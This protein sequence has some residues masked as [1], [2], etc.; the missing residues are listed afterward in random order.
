MVAV[1]STRRWYWL[2]LIALMFQGAADQANAQF[3]PSPQGPTAYAVPQSVP[4]ASQALATQPLS[5]P[6]AQQASFL[7][8]PGVRA[9]HEPAAAGAIPGPPPGP[10]SDLVVDVRVV[11]NKRIPTEKLMRYIKTR[12]GRPYSAEAVG[13]D[14][15]KLNGSGLVVSV[16]PQYQDAPNGQGRIVIYEVFERATIR[17]VHYVGNRKVKSRTLAKETKLKA[18]DP[19]EPFNVEEARNRLETF[20]KDKGFANARV[21]LSEGTKPTDERVVFVINEGPKQTILWASFEGNTIASEARLRTLIKSKQ[22]ILW[23]FGGELNRKQ[24]EE[25]EERLEA[26]YRSLGFFRASVGSLI[27]EHTFSDQRDWI[28]VKFVID[29]GP[30]YCVRNLSVVGN[31]KIDTAEIVR[32]IAMEQGQ[33][34]RQDDM[35]RDQNAIKD[36]YGAVGYIFADVKPDI[37]FLEEPG[38]LDLVY[39]I[40]EGERYRVGKIDVDIAGD[41]PHTQITTVLNRLSLEPGDIIDIRELRDSQRRLRASQLFKSDPQSGVMPEIAFSPPTPEEIEKAKAQFARRQAEAGQV[42]GQNP[43]GGFPAVLRQPPLAGSDRWYNVTFAGQAGSANSP[44]NTAPAVQPPSQPTPSQFSGAP[45][46]PPASVP[47]S[48][49]VNRGQSPTAPGFSRFLAPARRPGDVLRF[50]Y[51]ADSGSSTPPLPPPGTTPNYSATPAAP[52]TPYANPYAPAPENIAPNGGY[53][54]APQ[55]PPPGAAG[56]YGAPNPF[57]PGLNFFGDR[58]P[59]GFLG[60]VPNEDPAIFLPLRPEVA[61]TETGRFMFSAGVNSDAGVVG[62]VVVDEQNFDWR[63]F[64][65]GWEDFRNGTAFRGRGQRFRAEAMPGTEVQRYMVTFQEPYLFDTQ[66]SLG[67]NGFYYTRFFTE[68]D[69]QRIGGRVSLGYQLAH[70]L[71]ASGSFRFERVTISNPIG[72]APAELLDVV[73]DSDLYGFRAQLTHDTRDSTF[74]ATEGHLLTLA[75]EQV[76][77]TYQYPRAEIDLRKYFML[78]E[79]P[80]GSGRHVLSMKGTVNYTGSDTPIYEHYF[81]GGF[82]TIRGFD[83]RGASPRV[84]GVPV[85]G[86]FNLLASTEYMF[87]LTA[88]DTIRGVVFCDTGAAQPTIDNWSDKYRVAPG[89]GLRLTIP[90]MGPAPIA[91]DFAFPVVQEDGDEEEVFSF[92]IGFL[93]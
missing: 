53:V 37:R 18:G 90:A 31:K 13:E 30:R 54:P 8:N 91:L 57:D 48:E 32:V 88:S 76:I 46:W 42:R 11:G 20:Y 10:T 70:D 68:W 92:F 93:R 47:P 2:P 82:S 69:E 1:R 73:G 39:Q 14:V 35:R 55:L 26:Y 77:G 6:T 61:E 25:D 23:F 64:P 62:S 65:R 87:P 21:T 36:R 15:R 16:R 83:F 49:Y 29:E 78:H 50:Q 24:I 67:L 81:N 66:V 72:G 89:F 38:Q 3:L 71:S 34:F 51:S 85:G 86:E 59:G 84:N 52:A 17:S 44:S 5:Y 74:L 19:L 43:Q 80:D 63:R 4:Y 28:N 58:N 45:V 33:P 9:D 75:F 56:G 12:P 40:E 22:G 60:T 41:Y 7:S 27:E 79:R